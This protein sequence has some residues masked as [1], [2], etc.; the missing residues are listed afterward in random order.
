M[1][2]DL[3]GGEAGTKKRGAEA[4]A[5]AGSRSGKRQ[6]GR[7][8]AVRAEGESGKCGEYAR[9]AAMPSTSSIS[10]TPATHLAVNSPSFYPMQSRKY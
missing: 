3:R 5:E 1:N 9:K 2:W 6:A 4:T 7:E 8:K 10:I